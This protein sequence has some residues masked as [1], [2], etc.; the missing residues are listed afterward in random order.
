MVQ[1]YTH[2]NRVLK[3]VKLNQKLD[4]NYIFLFDLEPKEIL[5]N[6]AKSIRK[7][8]TEIITWFSL[9]RLIN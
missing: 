3:P 8:A 1:I 6:D 4:R 5:S 2:I 7:N 9:T